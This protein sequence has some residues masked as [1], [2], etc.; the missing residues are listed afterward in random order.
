MGNRYDCDCFLSNN[1]LHFIIDMNGKNTFQIYLYIRA[2]RSDR[3][4]KVPFTFGS[5]T[6][7]TYPLCQ[8]VAAPPMIGMN[9]VE[10]FS[11]NISGQ[12]Y[13]FMS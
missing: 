12:R 10:R 2:N 1:S 4:D 8:S 7:T 13:L 9:S 5:S 3:N 11:Q 6:L